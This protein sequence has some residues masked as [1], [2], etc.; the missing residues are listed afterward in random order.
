M[1]SNLSDYQL[2]RLLLCKMPY[3]NPMVTRNQRPVID[4]QKNK[5]EGIQPQH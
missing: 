3:L 5:K 2:N 4:T 1:H